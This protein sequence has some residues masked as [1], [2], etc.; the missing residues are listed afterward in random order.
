MVAAGRTLAEARARWTSRKP[1]RYEFALSIPNQSWWYR[2]FGRYRVTTGASQTIGALQGTEAETFST[3]GTID[4]LFDVI[5]KKLQTMSSRVSLYFDEEL[6]YPTGAFSDE[7][8][9]NVPAFRAFSTP[10]DVRDPYVLINHMNHCGAVAMHRTDLHVCPDYS[11]A[12]WGDGTVAYDGGAGVLT[13]DR[14]H[15]QVSQDAVRGIVQAVTAAGFFALA[16]DYSAKELPNGMMQFT[17]HAPEIW[18]T[19]HLGDQQKTIHDFAYGPKELT[20]LE[21]TIETLADVRRY[22]GHERH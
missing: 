2:S 14:H 10:S 6:G 13:L 12:I 21:S 17:D 22:T 18:V 20:A 15:H 16:N 11:V 4:G 19:I 3:A 9:F 8:S 5:A 7:F 1:S